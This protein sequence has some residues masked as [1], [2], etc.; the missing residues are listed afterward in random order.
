MRAA[1]GRRGGGHYLSFYEAASCATPKALSR[2]FAA[3]LAYC[4]PGAPRDMWAAFPPHLAEGGSDDSIS[5]AV[6]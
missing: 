6:S 2:I 5:N 3:I 4:S 1:N